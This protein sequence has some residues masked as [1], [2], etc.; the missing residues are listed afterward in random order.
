MI[1]SRAFTVKLCEN[2]CN[3]LAAFLELQTYVDKFTN[4]QDHSLWEFELTREEWEC[5]TQLVKVLQV[6]YL[7]VF[8]LYIR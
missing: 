4:V 1:S 5:V 3:H 6:S 7:I 8:D 2:S